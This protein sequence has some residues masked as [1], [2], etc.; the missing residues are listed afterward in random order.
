MFSFEG[1]TVVADAAELLQLQFICL[2]P[3]DKRRE[4][5]QVLCDGLEVLLVGLLF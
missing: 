1:L 4:M 3:C 5:I 2:E